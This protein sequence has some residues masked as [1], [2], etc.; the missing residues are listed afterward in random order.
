MF[1]VVYFPY[2]A[3]AFAVRYTVPAMTDIWHQFG[4]WGA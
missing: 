4:K 1:T 2:V 3:P